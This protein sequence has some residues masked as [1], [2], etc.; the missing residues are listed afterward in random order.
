LTVA[1][2]FFESV[3]AGGDV[4]LLRR[5]VH[6]WA[7]EH[8]IA[9]L[10]N[11]RNAIGDQSARLLVADMITPER[12]V[13]GPAEEEAVFTLDL[14]VLVLL[15]ARERSA[16][17][18]RVLLQAAGFRIEEVLATSPEGTIVASPV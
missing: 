11:C 13:S 12:A 10:A 8:A 16:S 1:G 4:Y 14:H 7:E 15:G 2:D 6:N 17:E 9:I 5:V 18:F 3:P